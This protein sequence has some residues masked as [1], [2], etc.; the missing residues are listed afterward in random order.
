MAEYLEETSVG[1]EQVTLI[2]LGKGH[3]IL[4]ILADGSKV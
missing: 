3:E 1:G 2:L 4:D